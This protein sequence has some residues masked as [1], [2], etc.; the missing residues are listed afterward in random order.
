MI[1]LGFMTGVLEQVFNLHLQGNI[2]KNNE[3]IIRLENL[4]MGTQ[5]GGKNLMLK[6]LL[7][8]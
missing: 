2:M 5:K 3:F 6:Q 7:N 1:V 8:F 4:F